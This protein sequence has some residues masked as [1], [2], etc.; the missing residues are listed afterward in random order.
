MAFCT[1]MGVQFE[2]VYSHFHNRAVL[3]GES[4]GERE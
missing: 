4:M 1:A 3:V 2:K